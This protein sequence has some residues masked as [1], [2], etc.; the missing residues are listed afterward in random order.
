MSGILHGAWQGHHPRTTGARPRCCALAALAAA[1]VMTWPLAPGLDRLGRTANSGDARVSVWNVAW[2]AHA[3]ARPIPPTCSTPTSSIPIRTRWRSPKPTWSRGRRAAGLVADPQRR[4]RPQRRRAVLVRG[5]GGHDVAARAP[6]DRRRLGR[7]HRGR[8]VR[9]L[10]VPVLAHR[11]HPAADGR[12]AAAGAADDASSRRRPVARHAAPALGLALAAQ[13]LACAY[14]G[15][16]AGFMVAYATLFLAWSRGLWRS[17]RATGPRSRWAPRCRSLLVAPAFAHYLQLQSET[18]FGRSL[19]RRDAVFGL[20]AIVSGL[21]GSRAQLDA[22][23]HQGLESRGAVPRLPGDRPRRRRESAC[24]ARSA[25]RAGTAAVRRPRDAGALWQPGRGGV[26]GIARSARRA[27]L[28]AVQDRPGVLA[29]ARARPHRH[30]GGAGAGAVRR[31]RRSRAE[32]AIPGPCRRRSR[33]SAAA[34]RSST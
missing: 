4:H 21:G 12:R 29:A 17:C 1:I 30:S 14:Y 15:I 20:S 22:V 19:A 2:V 3:L 33:C 7:G 24:A 16:F 26:L 5:V 28:A 23:D 25:G 31:L 6:A 27:L 8:A 32:T 13:A 9:L 11:P 10:P 18:G 34:P